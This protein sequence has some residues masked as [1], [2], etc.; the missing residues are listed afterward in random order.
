MNLHFPSRDFDEAV[1]AVCHGTVT[2]EQS[3]A[4]NGLLR[5]HPTARDEYILRL[6]LH[7]RLASDPE[8]FASTLRN[9]TFQ[10]A[11]SRISNPQPSEVSGTIEPMDGLPSEVR[12][13]SRLK[14]RS[15]THRRRGILT[16]AFG[17]VAC[18]LGGIIWWGL[19]DRPTVERAGIT[20]KAVAM[21]NRVVDA[22]WDQDDSTR[23]LGSPLE[24]GLLRLESGL[25]Q[26]VFYS[27]ARVVIEGPTEFEILSAGKAFCR[28]GRLTAEIPEQAI[29]FQIGTP[30]MNVTDLGTLF[31][32][33]VGEQGTE[34]HVFKGS[35]K[36]HSESES[37]H[38]VLREGFAATV[39]SAT[40]PRLLT[41][42]RAGFVS[43]FGLLEK[44]AAAETLRYVE[45]RQESNR[46]Q[47]DP[48]LL[49]YLDFEKDSSSDW[50]L[51]NAANNRSTVPDASIVGCQ[52]TSGRWPDKHAL[53]FQSV[54]DRV[55]LSVPGEFESLTLAAWVRIHGLDRQINSLFMSDGFAPGTVHWLIRNDGVLG[56]TVIGRGIGNY[57]IVTSPPVIT[58]GQFGM[59][60]HLAVIMD[61]RNGRVMFFLNGRPIADK[62][63]RIAP[64]YLVGE[65]ELGN[66]NARGFPDDD[67]FLIR[68]FSGAM[69]EFC[70]FS[71][72][73]DES[74]IRELYA[75]G[76]PRPEPLLK[77]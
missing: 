37:I 68:H 20:S 14:I 48:S 8:L 4:L 51:I 58:L 69:D 47:L 64:P 30:Q 3:L 41:A 12:R 15:I 19:Q 22:Q 39:E 76:N 31:G 24:P 53:E 71:R 73:L 72:A 36:F 74:E 46:L 45:W 27:G 60:L 29:G 55:R 67:P 62:P 43:L 52:W 18:L 49:V 25:A 77:R 26:I 61:G 11:V 1:A 63:L 33:E 34:L 17:M 6:E 7:S 56:M 38:H 59:W 44:S 13:S 57:Q 10:P 54:N 50:R 16:G 2:D 21:L 9:T 40:T 28:N 65:A 75:N 70:L 23:Q 35:V 32:L 66:W 42:N 5:H